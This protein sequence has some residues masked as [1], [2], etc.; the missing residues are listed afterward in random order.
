LRQLAP[1]SAAYEPYNRGKAELELDL[2]TPAGAAALRELALGADVLVDGLRP[3]ALE[4]MGL[5]PVALR[6][7]N[8]RLIYCALSAYGIDGPAGDKAGHDLN[9]VALSGLLAA[10]TVG[11][12]PAMPGTQLADL[13]SALSA[14]AAIL[15]ALNQRAASGAG[16]VLDAPMEAAAGWLMQP[17]YAVERAAQAAGQAGR[18]PSRL[19]VGEAAYY[20]SYRTADGRYLAVAALEAHFWARFCAGLG[21]PELAARQHD[22][23]QEALAREVA[24]CIRARTLAAWRAIFDDV[25]AC[26]TPVLSVAEAAERAPKHAGL[27]VS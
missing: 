21:R 4:R 9:L 7:S 17:W 3:G 18:R 19:L 12:E 5:G 2:K 23:D 8:P 22:L 6:A 13:V 25:D 27:P 14:A 24:A 10:T 16:C 1:L 11:G 26:V 15:A 20:R